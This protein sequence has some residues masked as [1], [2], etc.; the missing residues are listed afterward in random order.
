MELWALIVLT[1][2]V[3]T[4]AGMTLWAR[5]PRQYR[6]PDPL[7]LQAA[8]GEVFLRVCELLNRRS[9]G[10][11]TWLIRDQI[12]AQFIQAEL[13]Y[14]EVL[15][16]EAVRCYATFNFDFVPAGKDCSKLR[17]SVQYKHWCD[18][19]TSMR[20]EAEVDDWIRAM[21][22][23]YLPRQEAQDESAA[24]TGSLLPLASQWKEADGATAS[25]T[26]HSEAGTAK[27]GTSRGGTSRGGTLSCRIPVNETFNRLSK[28]LK[29][30]RST[31]RK[32]V[33]LQRQAPVLLVSELRCKTDDSDDDVDVDVEK[34]ICMFKITFKLKP[35]EDS[36]TEVEWSYDFNHELDQDRLN[37][38][39]ELTDDWVKLVLYTPRG[40]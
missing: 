38:E 14:S 25:S 31:R 3:M 24:Q 15:E 32:W 9:F 6:S 23:E 36:R 20:L 21:L 16:N 39:K 28:R 40:A 8:S 19:E 13:T 29:D 1:T 7:E 33:I 18:R 12:E 27:G 30:D 2:T 4:V 22:Y 17:W 37:A 10:N 34:F 11:Q 26:A 35:G 5:R